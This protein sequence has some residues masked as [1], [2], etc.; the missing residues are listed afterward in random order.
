MTRRLNTRTTDKPIPRMTDALSAYYADIRKYPRLNK[1]ET[2][3]L[4]SEMRLG[5]EAADKARESVIYRL[6]RFVV[7]VA[8]CYS[9]YGEMSDLISEGNLGLMRAVELYNP[10]SG[11]EITSYAVFWIRK[12]IIQYI[13]DQV[14]QVRQKN[15]T[16][17]VTYSTKANSLFFTEH[18]RFPTETELADFIEERYGEKIRDASDLTQLSFISSDTEYGESI[19]GS[20]TQDIGKKM[21]EEKNRHDVEVMMSSLNDRERDII[22]SYYGIGGQNEESALE[23]GARLS[24]SEERVRQI[25]RDAIK[26]LNKKY[27]KNQN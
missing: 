17:R 5:G 23:I 19:F 1:D 8:R 13:T 15:T 12:Y 25:H 20:V 18:G 9:K 11:N 27:G 7:S 3:R 22:M 10:E 6:Q 2:C 26:K 14:P 24:L 21:N 4:F 16:R